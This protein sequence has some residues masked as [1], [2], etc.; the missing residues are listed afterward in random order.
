MS[1]TVRYIRPN[2]HGVPL[3]IHIYPERDNK[4]TPFSLATLQDRYLQPGETPQHMFARVACSYGFDD[5]HAQRLYNAMSNLWF[6]PSTPILS[7]GGLSQGNPISCF[8][9]AVPDTMPGIAD[10]WRENVGLASKGGGIGTY[11][12]DVREIGAPVGNVGSTSGIMPFLKVQDSMTM[13]VNQGSL[14]RGSA[15]AYLDIDHPEIEAFIDSR[16]PTGDPRTRCLDLHHGV[17]ITDAFMNAVEDDKDWELKARVTGETVELVKARDL[18]KKLLLTRME[19]G[20]PYL[21]FIDT[22]QAA[23]PTHHDLLGLYPRQSNLCSEITLPTNEH[24]TAVCC[25]ASLNAETY[26]DWTGSSL[27][28]DVLLMLDNVLQDFINKTK[29]D[30]AFSKARHSAMQERSVG[31][32]LMGFH[33]YLQSKRIPFGSALASSANH[34]IFAEIESRS[35]NAN[36]KAADVLGPCPDSLQVQT[37]RKVRWSYTR[38]VAPTASISIICGQTSPGVEPMVANAFTHKTLSGSFSVR[39]RHLDAILRDLYGSGEGYEQ[40]WSSIVANEGSVQQLPH[41]TAEDKEV[42]KTAF[43][44]SPAWQLQHMVDRA[45]YVDQAVSNNL[46][47]RP[48]INVRELRDIHFNAWKRGVKSLYYCR[49]KASSRAASVSGHVAGEMPVPEQYNSRQYEECLPCQ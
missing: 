31:L 18:W 17:V 29:G 20:E 6:M 39:N 13:A 49:S 41:L 21:L 43:E 32:G 48:D 42:F 25:L 30:P 19:T 33:S 15:A 3:E 27:V 22:V 10:T 2:V 9:N 12:G 1:Q 36:W 7:N 11:W 45:P 14:R 16:R 23:T 4:L 46:F 5:Q 47:L 35:D 38:A 40:S 44:I 37:N 8:L 28:E 26:D 34:K 24:R